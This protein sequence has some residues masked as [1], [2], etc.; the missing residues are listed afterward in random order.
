MES[1]RASRRGEPRGGGRASATAA[2]GKRRVPGAMESTRGAAPS[3]KLRDRGND[4]PPR[5][6]PSGKDG[7]L[8]EPQP[9]GC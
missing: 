1:P 9:V 6:S 7:T 4:L 8:Q 5:T 2:R 3:G